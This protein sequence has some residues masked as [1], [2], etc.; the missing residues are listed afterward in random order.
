MP[1]RRSMHRLLDGGVRSMRRWPVVAASYVGA[2]VGA[3]FGSGREVAHFFALHGTAGLAGALLAGA[4]F[5]WCGAVVL[6]RAATDGHRH[7]GDLLQGICGPRL[8]PAMD[9]L[10]TVFLFLT[11]ATVLAGAGALT[12]AWG[13]ARWQGAVGLGIALLG[14]AVWGQRGHLAVNAVLV[15]LLSALTLW[16]CGRVLVAQGLHAL[17][18]IPPWSTPP[19]G[20]WPLAAVLYV[21]YNLVLALAGMCASLG[22]DTEPADAARGGLAGGL[23]LSFLCVA[24]C[25]SLLGMGAEA[26]RLELPLRAAF[27]GPGLGAP[28]FFLCLAAALWTTGSAAISALS[29]RLPCHPPLF[30]AAAGLALALPLGMAGLVWLVAVVYPLMGYAGLPLLVCMVVASM[31]ARRPPA[32]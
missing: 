32:T 31:R 22:V 15:P 2:V 4:F 18:R 12:G 20:G 10:M 11:V 17:L 3:G 25:A 29:L 27:P 5:T 28:L 8:G 30:T 14:T 9:G 16:A 6:R 7:Y 23:V 24:L 13:G 19:P 1:R 26:L 21:A